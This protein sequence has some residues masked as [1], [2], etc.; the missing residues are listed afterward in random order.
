MFL[1]D[2]LLELLRQGKVVIMQH[3]EM[4]DYVLRYTQHEVLRGP[5]RAFEND[6]RDKDTWCVPLPCAASITA[7]TAACCD[8]DG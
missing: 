1:E 5:I 7:G 6:L 2:L 4:S 8:V 3:F